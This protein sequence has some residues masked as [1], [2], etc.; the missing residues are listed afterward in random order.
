MNDAVSLEEYKKHKAT[1]G[2]SF[3]DILSQIDKLNRAVLGEPELK[4]KGLVEMTSAM[5]ES[6]MMARSGEKIFIVLVKI[7][8]AV[9]TVAA[10]FWAVYEFLTRIKIN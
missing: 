5:Y 10:A 8:G 9:A 6:V 7:A 4:Q 1:C 3:E 2:K